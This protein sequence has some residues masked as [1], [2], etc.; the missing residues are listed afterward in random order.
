MNET[1]ARLTISD[2]IIAK[3]DGMDAMRELMKELSQYYSTVHYIIRNVCFLDIGLDMEIRD[4]IVLRFNSD[5]KKLKDSMKQ[6]AAYQ[7]ETRAL[8]ERMETLRAG[9]EEIFNQS[10]DLSTS[11]S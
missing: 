2:K 3:C 5:M 7:R 8:L 9:L 4:R 11:Q 6:L 1:P 10:R